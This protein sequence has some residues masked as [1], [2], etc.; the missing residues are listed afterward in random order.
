MLIFSA[1]GLFLTYAV[2][3]LQHLLPLN[4]DKMAAVPPD[5]AWNT[6]TSFA[7][8][9]NWQAYSGES[10][11]SH[12]TQMVGLTFHNFISAATGIVLAIA[13]IRGIARG[14]AKTSAISGWTSPAAR[15]GCCCRCRLPRLSS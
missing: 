14:S 6:A 4:P 15:F 3:R 9:T 12:F 1:I 11:M 7:T 2:E 8:N 13:I 10:M 5:L